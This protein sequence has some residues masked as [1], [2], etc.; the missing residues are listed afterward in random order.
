M[1]PPTAVDEWLAGRRF[2][3]VIDAGS[4]GSRLQIYSWRDARL[5]RSEEGPKA[6]RSLPKVEKGTED[7]ED[8]V[9]KVEPGISSF[10]D[11]PD[12]VA[13]YLAPLLD[14][15]REHI[16]PSL[17]H[18]TPIFLLA[19]AG[20]RL[21]PPS[22]QTA[23]LNAACNFVRFHSYF[24]VESASSLGR[25]GSSIRIITGE[26]EGLFGWIAVNYLMDQFTNEEDDK[27]TYGFLDMGG[28]STQIAFEPSA[29]ERKKTKNLSDVRLRLIG[30]EEIHHQVF[31]TTW[32]GYGTNQARER[33]VNET[34]SHYEISMD[35][36]RPEVHI[37]DPCL[38]RDL[39]LSESSAHPGHANMLGKRTHTLLGTGSYE[40]CLKQVAPLLN[41]DAPCP[42]APCLFNGVH[43]P[44]IDFSASHFIGVS[45]Y[46]YS[47]EHVFGLGGAYNFVEFERAA[48]EF[49]GRDWDDI[50]RQH[51][52]SKKNDR[53]GG[54]GEVEE[55][56]RIVDT[57]KWG[58][59]V[60]IPR[61]QMQCFKSAWLVNV[62]HDGIGMP[63]I[64]D[65]EGN[66]RD[67]SDDVK[68]K[69]N[70][71]GLGKPVMQS[72]DT[73]GD[74]AISWTLGK[75]VLEA[76]REIP[77]LLKDTPALSDPD[78][79]E[80]P[81]D[82]PSTD[83]IGSDLDA[84]HPPQFLGNNLDSAPLGYFLYYVCL[85]LLVA[86]A[87]RLRYSIANC[88]RRYLRRNVWKGAL[89]DDRIS[90]EGGYYPN[91]GRFTATGSPLLTNFSPLSSAS[92]HWSSMRSSLSRLLPPFYRQS[93]PPPSSTLSAT[94]HM[95]PPPSRASPT[96]SFSSPALR[97]QNG[98]TGTTQHAGTYFGSSN[99]PRSSTP[100]AYRRDL[101]Q[102]NG[103]T[104]QSLYSL[105]RSRNN[106]QMN[107]T[108]LVTRQP[109]S[110]GGSSGQ[111]TP[112]SA[113]H[114]GE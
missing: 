75:M 26:Q 36:D 72:L 58:D 77:P 69:A 81:D 78:A 84:T 79:G 65:P 45:E 3:I 74:T 61:L 87:Y 9:R 67:S 44:R 46:W 98:P 83:R 82:G 66:P 105:P 57:G 19:T 50:L 25:C 34:I 32:L 108:T 38:P 31:V 107:L 114:E 59:E 5:V 42:D 4:S 60:E 40:Q 109:L 56:G 97:N 92:Q 14:H 2:G 100:P 95:H 112:T 96:R 52:E 101:T 104:N 22:Q 15:A 102:L 28:A 71:K 48:S 110:R 80:I 16:P 10:G 21:L 113:Y 90:L 73:I 33:Y 37:P 29:E 63:R 13:N 43:V 24:R 8:W 91:G 35:E 62:L 27:T 49:C 103:H 99:P 41:K 64:V 111:Q 12:A 47:S 6:Y 68:D 85:V 106:S 54:D 39:E 7:A 11:N 88:S 89:V 93:T 17:Q 55:G 70:Q 76:S 51:R 94:R 86:I 1:P 20:M 30:G 53:L 18:E 23:V